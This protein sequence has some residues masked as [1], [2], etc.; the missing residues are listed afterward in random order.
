MSSGG[1]IGG[2][3]MDYF[4]GSMAFR[5]F[6]CCAL[7]LC[8]LHVIVQL[9]FKRYCPVVEQPI[10]SEKEMKKDMPSMKTDEHIKDTKIRF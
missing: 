3:A 7:I 4:G 2:Y 6:G 10:Q 1:V 8:A 5:W 9:M